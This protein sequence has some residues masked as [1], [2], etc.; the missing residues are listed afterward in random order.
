[1]SRAARDRQEG[2]T[3]AEVLIA[4]LIMVVA[5]IPIIGMFDGAL[6]SVRLASTVHASAACAESVTEQVKATP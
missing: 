4:G 5:L 1:M 2:F 3:L 6:S